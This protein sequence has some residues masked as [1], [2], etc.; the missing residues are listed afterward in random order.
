MRR[1]NDGRRCSRRSSSCWKRSKSYPPGTVL[2]SMTKQADVAVFD[3]IKATKERTLQG[4]MLVLG[5]KEDGV[6]YVHEGPHAVGI[7][8]ATKKRVEALRREVIDGRVVVP[9]E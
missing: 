6:D 1:R 3:A 8:D 7:S 5:L 9:F 2:T 4:G